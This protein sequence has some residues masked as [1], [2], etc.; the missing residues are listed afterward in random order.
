M[1][2]GLS[3]ILNN[4]LYEG[5]LNI[6]EGNH[7][8]I[9]GMGSLIDGLREIR[10]EINPDDIRAIHNGITNIHDGIRD[11]NDI[12][13]DILHGTAE[14]DVNVELRDGIKRIDE[15]LMEIIDGFRDVLEENFPA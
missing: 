10:F 11:I 4:K 15:G 1:Q 2:E 14:E 5:K 6:R 7:G 13:F 8:V 12:M 3:E 9:K